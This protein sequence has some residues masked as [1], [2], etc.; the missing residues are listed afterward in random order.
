MSFNTW[1]KRIF[2][3]DIANAKYETDKVWREA[4]QGNESTEQAAA[5]RLLDYYNRDRT[6]MLKHIQ[7][8]AKKT[9][10]SEINNVWQFPFING[11]PRTIKRLSQAYRDPPVR[12]LVRGDKVLATDDKAYE[13]LDRLYANLDPNAKLKN[14]DQYSTLLNTTH[15]EVVPRNGSVDWD[16]RLRPKTTILEDPN[17]YLEFIKLAYS[18]AI[19][20]PDTLERREGWVYW[21]AEEHFFL[22]TDKLKVGMSNED[23]NNL[24]NPYRDRDKNQ[25]IPI[26]TIR[27]VEQDEY[28]GRYGADLVDAIEAANLQLA[29]L[30]E[31][32]FLQTHGIPIGTNLGTKEGETIQTGPREGFFQENMTKDDLPADLKFAKPDPDIKEMMDLIDWYIK[33]TGATYGL[34]P[35]AWAL[36][37]TRMSGIAKFLDNLELLESREDEVAMW[38]RIEQDLFEKSRIVYNTWVKDSA[39]ID[40]DLELQVTFPQTSFPESPTEK[41]Q[42]F[43]VELQAGLT[44]PVEWFIEEEGLDEQQAR[45]KAKRIAKDNS[46]LKRAGYEGLTKQIMADSGVSE[47]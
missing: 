14:A 3:T 8:A 19:V 37:E 6:E 39:K 28:W 23:P 42:R 38:Q 35:S 30:W 45:D 1:I 15:V 10:G 47:E 20:N 25:V 33:Q 31:N 27:K 11:V 32:G 9:F 2:S 17:N 26:V 29:N 24:D 40:M 44:S 36:D 34:P 5:K 21:S 41:I 12:E 43:L 46:E 7:A 13:Q 16:F 22:G 4:L 18:F